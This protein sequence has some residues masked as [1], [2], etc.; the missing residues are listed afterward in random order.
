M[1]MPSFSY[2]LLSQIIPQNNAEED[3]ISL[4][5]TFESSSSSEDIFLQIGGQTRGSN[6]MGPF[7]GTTESYEVNERNY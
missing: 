2:K 4:F 6:R 7:D 3:E 5:E 1:K